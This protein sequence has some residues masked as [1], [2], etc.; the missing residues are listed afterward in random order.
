M[1]KA[2]ILQEIK[3][4]AKENGGVPLGRSKFE[5]E[6]GIKWSDWFGKFWARWSDAVREAGLNPNELTSAYDKKELLEKFAKLT[7][8]LGRLP[9]SGDLRLKTRSDEEFP[10][11]STFENRFGTKLELVKQLL[12]HCQSNAEFKSVVQLCESYIAAN[13]NIET[14]DEIAEGEIG[15]V[16]LIK[17]GRFYK[18]GRANS[19]GR[20]EY[21]LAIQLPEKAK[22]VHVIRTDDPNGIEAY[23]HN[24]FALKRKNGEWFDLNT[25]DIAAFKRRKFM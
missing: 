18:I 10:S 1:N 4:T 25:S 14:E 2:H 22:T 17:S 13:D 6:T 9:S 16:Y 5:N 7:L 23:W 12:E 24:R 11:N 19:A 21:E 15:F 20:R 8:E 3:R